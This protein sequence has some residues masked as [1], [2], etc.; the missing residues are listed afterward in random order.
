[1][2]RHWNVLSKLRKLFHSMTKHLGHP[3]EI[4]LYAVPPDR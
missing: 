1:V 3:R 2:V 4:T